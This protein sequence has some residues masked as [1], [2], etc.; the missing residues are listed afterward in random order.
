MPLGVTTPPP[1][2]MAPTLVVFDAV[3]TVNWTVP[4]RVIWIFGQLWGGGG[5]GARTGFPGNAGGASRIMR[6]AATLLEALGGAGANGNDG[7]N[8]GGA[9][10]QEVIAGQKGGDRTGGSSPRG[11]GGGPTGVTGTVPGGGGGGNLADGTAGGGAGGYGASTL[12]TTPGETLGITVGAGGAPGLA[13]AGPGASGR[14]L[15]MYWTAPF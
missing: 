15:I 3:G 12:P 7:G 1:F 4:A 13:G 11:G 8:G 2:L 6:G 10:G 5:G 9:T 14:V